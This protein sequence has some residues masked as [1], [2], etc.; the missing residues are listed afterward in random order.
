VTALTAAD[1]ERGRTWALTIAAELLR[2]DGAAA[3]FRD[4]ARSAAG[5]ADSASVGNRAP[6]TASRPTGQAQRDIADPI[7]TARTTRAKTPQ[8]GW[9]DFSARTPPS[10]SSK[11]RTKSGPRRAARPSQRFADTVSTPA[12]KSIPPGSPGATYRASRGL[13]EAAPER[14]LWIAKRGPANAR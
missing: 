4:E 14:M 5:L 6:G 7:P 8:P 12:R 2:Q 3:P 11:P 10:G 13:P 9:P 1:Y